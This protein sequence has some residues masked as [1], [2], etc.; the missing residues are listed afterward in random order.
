MKTDLV[1][2]IATAAVGII[3]AY[4]ICNM[5]LP[6]LSDVTIK[7]LDSGTTY[8]LTPPDPEVFNYRS[9]NPTVEVYVGQCAEY[10]QYG[11][12]IENIEYVENEDIVIEDE[13][14]DTK[15]EENK[16]DTE[17]QEDQPEV[18]EETQNGT[19]N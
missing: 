14:T 5:V 19:S 1:T 18:N 11:E 3:A 8:T 9:I 6:P 17:N 10:N 2:S 4:F 7:T 13:N 15:A 12:C 16:Q